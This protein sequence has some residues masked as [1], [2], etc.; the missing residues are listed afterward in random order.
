MQ[1]APESCL[2]SVRQPVRASWYCTT[3]FF[4]SNWPPPLPVTISAAIVT[5]SLIALQFAISLIQHVLEESVL[6][7]GEKGEGQKTNKFSLILLFLRLPSDAFNARLNMLIV[8]CWTYGHTVLDIVSG[9]CFLDRMADFFC[10]YSAVGKLQTFLLQWRS[11]SHF[12]CIL[13]PFV[14]F[15]CCLVSLVDLSI[16]DLISSLVVS[17]SLICYSFGCNCMTRCWVRNAHFVSI[18]PNHTHYS[19]PNSSIC[20]FFYLFFSVSLL[21]LSLST[22]PRSFALVIIENR[23]WPK[24]TNEAH[25]IHH[26]FS[27][28]LAYQPILMLN[29]WPQAKSGNFQI[30]CFF[31]VFIYFILKIYSLHRILNMMLTTRDH[32]CNI[33]LKERVEK[34]QCIIFFKPYLKQACSIQHTFTFITV[35][36]LFLMGIVAI[37][38][39]GKAVVFDSCSRS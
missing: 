29:S 26:S 4:Y 8:H 14:C 16:C 7:G 6:V 2:T 31:C 32:P 25:N 15:L 20:S 22:P 23:N 27:N 35:S 17:A 34:F 37:K 19:V 21:L 30:C 12:W 13:S 9:A 3:S 28:Q 24:R 33:S 1:N 38:A 10:V 36:F 5:W 39:D 11:Y 18:E